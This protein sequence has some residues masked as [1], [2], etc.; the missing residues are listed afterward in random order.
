MGFNLYAFDKKNQTFFAVAQPVKKEVNFDRLVPA[1]I[2]GYA[3][4]LTNNLLK[5][6]SDCQRHFD[7]TSAQFLHSFI[8]SFHC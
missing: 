5:I 2:N 3:L 7:L 4:L 6:S 1:N 8:F